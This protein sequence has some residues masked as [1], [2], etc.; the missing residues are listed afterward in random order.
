MFPRFGA[1]MQGMNWKAGGRF[2]RWKSRGK[3]GMIKSERGGTIA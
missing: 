1:E 2:A 3:K